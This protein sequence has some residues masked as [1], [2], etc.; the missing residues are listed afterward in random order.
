MP[1]TQSNVDVSQPSMSSV[2]SNLNI[3]SQKDSPNPILG[4]QKQRKV[5]DDAI[6]MTKSQKKSLDKAVTRYF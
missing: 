3:S 6:I 1:S 5:G 2:S 4:V